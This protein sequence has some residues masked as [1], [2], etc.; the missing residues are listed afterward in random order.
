M[1]FVALV[2]LGILARLGKPEG[3]PV[4]AARFHVLIEAA[5]LAYAM[6]DKFVADPDM[7]D[8]PVEHMLSDGFLDEM[9]GRIDP[10]RRTPDLG[11]IPD[12]SGSDNRLP[13]R[14]R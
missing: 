5:R 6:R 4:S 1:A 14:H 13:D 10:K 7:A 11:P 8:V 3:G 9:A 2:M 12:A